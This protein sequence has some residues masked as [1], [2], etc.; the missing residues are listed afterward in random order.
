MTYKDVVREMFKAHPNK[1][2]KEVMRMAAAKWKSMKGGALSHSIKKSRGGGVSGGGIIGDV[3]H[4]AVG[5]AD[6]LGSLF[7]LGLEG[8]KGRRMPAKGRKA[9]GAGVSGGGVIGD[10]GHTA[11]D[12]ADKLG[13]LFGLGLQHKGKMRKGRKTRGAGVSGGAADGGSLLSLFGLGLPH[14][15]GVSGGAADGGSLLSLLGLGLDKPKPAKGGSLLGMFGLGLDGKPSAIAHG[16]A[17]PKTSARGGYVSAGGITP[18]YY[19]N[20]SIG[21][22]QPF[23]PSLTNDMTHGGNIL[24]SAMHALPFMALL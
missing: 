17:R 21:N 8:K 22:V 5:L 19:R 18:T 10:V 13:D 23:Q 1:A 16:G 15:G 14:G 4:T 11:V 6:S 7:G 24:S 2:P 9:R 12:V 3:G 20:P